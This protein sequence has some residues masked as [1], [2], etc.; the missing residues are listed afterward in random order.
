MSD[1]PEEEALSRFAHAFGS[2][3]TAIQGAVRMLM[4]LDK[5]AVPEEEQLLEIIERNCQRLTNT[6]QRLLGYTSVEGAVVKVAL[7]LEQLGNSAATPASPAASAALPVAIEEPALPAG[8]PVIL[9]VDDDPSAREALSQPLRQAGYGVLTAAD[10]TAAVDLARSHPPDMIT[11]DLDMPGVDGPHLLTV[12]KQDPVLKDVPVLVVSVLAASGRVQVPGAVGA[13]AKPIR[14]EILLQAVADILQA[15]AEGMPRRGKIL[16][17]DD[18]ED[19]RRTLAADLTEQGYAVFALAEGSATVEAVRFWEPDLVLLDLHLPDTDGIDLL[20]ILKEDWR[21]GRTPVVLLSAEQR[22]EEKA[23]AFRGGADD[24]V[25]K[26]FS[27]VEL[28]ARME[29]VLRRKE[30]EFSLNPSTHLPGNTTIERVLRQ[31]IASGTP[32][33]VCYIDLDNFKAYNDVYGFLRGDGIIH[34]TAQVLAEAVRELGNPEDFLGHVGGDDFIL[35]TTPDRAEAICQRVAEEFGRVIPLYYDAEARARGYIQGEDRQGRTVR[36][37][38]MTIS[39]VIVSNDRRRIEHPGQIADVAAEL[40]RKAK[41]M[42][43]NTILR[44]RRSM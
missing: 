7:P 39:Q 22:P 12:L 9:V 5:E 14:R 37:P 25:T 28:V 42:P 19:I 41:T 40:K 32:F 24:Y 27:N 30:I 36:F 31:Q 3:L 1:R 38:L 11:L 6:V 26:P 33:A 21:T 18:E 44:D 10:S 29:A 20:H 8:R 4:F 13:L 43:G 15:P 2:P 23:R 34:Q 16:L 17:V 35:V